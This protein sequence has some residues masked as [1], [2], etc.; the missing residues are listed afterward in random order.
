MLTPEITPSYLTTNQSKE[1]PWT[2]QAT[3]HPLPYLTFKNPSLKAIGEFRSFEHELP[4][5][6]WHPGINAVLSF[7][8][9][10]YQQIGFTVY[11]ASRSKFALVTIIAPAS[12]IQGLNELIYVKHLELWLTQ[13]KHCRNISCCLSLMPFSIY[14]DTLLA[15]ERIKDQ[16][17]YGCAFPVTC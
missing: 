10:W 17:L 16:H 1:C 7:T 12:S 9:T 15:V 5:L 4:I 2:D 6:A 14:E 8:T 13:R 3:W 11:W